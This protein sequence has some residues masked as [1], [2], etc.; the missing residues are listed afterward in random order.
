MLS[1]RELLGSAAVLGTGGAAESAEAPILFERRLVNCGEPVRF[2]VQLPPAEAAAAELRIFPRYL[3]N[4]AK[5]D[6]RARAGR[7]A[8]LDDVPSVKLDPTRGDLS[9]TTAEPGNHMLRLRTPTAT[10]YRYF[11]AVQPNYLVYRMLAYSPVQPP[12]DAPEL[13]NGGF[14]I[15]WTL[16]TGRLPVMLD[17]ARGHL[18]LL[19]EAQHGFG[20]IVMP[21]FDTATRAKRRGA[22]SVAPYVDDVLERMRG[23]GLEVRRAVLDWSVSAGSV[24]LYRRRGFDVVD[25]VI[26]EL[27]DHRGASWFPYWMSEGDFLSP[28]PGPTAQMG[29]IMDFCPG[30]HFHGPPDFHMIASECNWGVAAA[31][32]DLAAREHVLVARNSRGGPV[33]VPTLLVFEYAK[34]GTWP[35]RDWT[36]GRQLDFI[37]NFLDDTAFEHARKYPIVFARATDIA[38]YLRAHPAPQPRRILSSITHDWKYDRIWSPEDYNYGYDVHVGVRPFGESLA[39]IRKNRKYIWAKPA[40]R[41]LIYYED[42]QSQCRFEYACPKPMLWYDYGDHRSRGPFEGRA[43]VDVP[44]PH[45]ELNATMG[46]GRFQV[47]YRLSGGRSFRGY[48]LALWD[49]PREFARGK[50]ETNAREFILVENSDGDYRGIL[51][52]DLEPET[53]IRLTLTELNT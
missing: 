41:E 9:F 44:D 18:A 21:F 10:F 52:F 2:R 14:P 11:A 6:A 31:H 23:A 45:V 7:M 47:R 15:D 13:R 48:R 50:V 43:E 1:R 4:S 53:E 46:A 3:E 42:A 17:P 19:K 24:E 32:A 29:M 16:N 22:A 26:P 30:F 8:W 40:A 39:N 51:V 27:A 49:I 20:D 35:A 38:D 28:A 36:R 33:F 12:T 25:G 5:A 37:R 34:Q